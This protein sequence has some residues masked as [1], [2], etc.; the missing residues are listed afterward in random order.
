[1]TAE[2]GRLRPCLNNM[3]GI[4]PDPVAFAKQLRPDASF[5]NGKRD[6][7]AESCKKPA[8]ELQCMAGSAE[9]SE[10]L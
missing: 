2:N 7:L 3:K 10:S 4:I 8:L 6:T 1:M 5:I 9:E